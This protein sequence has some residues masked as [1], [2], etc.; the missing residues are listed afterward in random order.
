[1][2]FFEESRVRESSGCAGRVGEV[3]GGEGVHHVGG[4]EAVAGGKRSGGVGRVVEWVRRRA[5]PVQ[6]Y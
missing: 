5:Y 3:V 6:A 2:V 1:M 4:A